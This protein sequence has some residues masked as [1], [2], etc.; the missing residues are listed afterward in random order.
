M[1]CS[2]HVGLSYSDSL[3][4]IDWCVDSK[5]LASILSC[6]R[7]LKV[8]DLHSVLK[9]DADLSPLLQLP[10]SCTDLRISGHAFG[11]AAAPI[12]VQLQHLR[13]LSWTDGIWLT[14]A[15]LEQLTALQGLQHLAVTGMQYCLSPALRNVVLSHD[16]D[17]DE[18][19]ACWPHIKVAQVRPRTSDNLGWVGSNADMAVSALVRQAQGSAVQ[20]AAE[21]H[22]VHV[23]RRLMPCMPKTVQDAVLPLGAVDAAHLPQCCMQTCLD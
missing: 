14:D 2:H 11:D 5:D 18:V 4:H 16:A 6:C 10:V 1:E 12:I 20:G 13:R 19:G 8:L 17:A 9:P 22:T 23:G 15:G 7:G 21:T 3:Q